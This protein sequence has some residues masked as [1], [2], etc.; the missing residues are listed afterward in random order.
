MAPVIIGRREEVLDW[1]RD[2]SRPPD[3]LEVRTSAG[4]TYSGIIVVD[5]NRVVAILAARHE[6]AASP[7]PRPSPPAPPFQDP[8]CREPWTHDGDLFRGR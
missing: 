1:V 2:A 6:T 5:H 7:P 8:F 3:G 4:E